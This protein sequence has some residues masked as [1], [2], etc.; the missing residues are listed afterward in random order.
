MLYKSFLLFFMLQF[1]LQHDS[2]I[3]VLNWHLRVEKLPMK[4]FIFGFQVWTDSKIS[5]NKPSARRIHPLIQLAFDVYF[6][7]IFHDWRVN[8]N[9]IKKSNYE[10]II[11]FSYSRFDKSSEVLIHLIFLFTNLSNFLNNVTNV[12]TYQRLFNACPLLRALK[13]GA[14]TDAKRAR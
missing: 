6:E 4:D 10:F 8:T 3:L 13:L 12:A 9:I 1:D 2:K 11:E 14:L 5:H 7:K